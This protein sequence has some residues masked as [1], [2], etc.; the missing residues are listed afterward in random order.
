ML[1]PEER[2]EGKLYFDMMWRIDPSLFAI[3][4]ENRTI[5]PIVLNDIPE[6]DRDNLRNVPPILGSITSESQSSLFDA[7]IPVIKEDLMD[8]LP[9]AVFDYI[10]KQAL[11]T[12][13]SNT[14]EFN[15]AAFPLVNLYGIALW[16]AINSD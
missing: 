3:P 7:L 13:I 10:N 6:I 9:K 14:T 4:F 5:N 15:K 8:M 16:N 2:Q 11:A 12:L 1:A